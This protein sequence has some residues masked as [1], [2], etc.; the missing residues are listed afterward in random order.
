MTRTNTITRAATADDAAAIARI[1]NQGIEDGAATFETRARTAED[2]AA[3]LLGRA[4]RHPTLV[5]SRDRVIV[6]WASASLYRDRACYDDVA[7]FSIYVERGERAHG[8]GAVLLEA[9]CDECEQRGFTKLLSRIF[10]ENE[11]SRRLCAKLGFHEV[12]V[13]R[14]HGQLHGVWRDCVIVERLLGAARA[15]SVAPSALDVALDF[16]ARI[17]AHDSAALAVL[18]SEGHELVDSLGGSSRGR[19]ALEKGWAGY[20]QRVPDYAIEITAH[21]PHGDDVALFGF[22]GGTF[23]PDGVLTPENRWRIPA[24]WLATVRDGRVAKWRIF[25]DNKPMHEQ[26]ARA[27]ARDERR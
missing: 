1:Y 15:P 12:G 17:N 18:M 2:I 19:D 22:A 3:S 5:A 25:A 27:Q 24:A 10:V 13:Y 16:V 21:F 11:G 6:G 4:T 26:L 23:A 9:L 8:I 20:F 7:E 14:R